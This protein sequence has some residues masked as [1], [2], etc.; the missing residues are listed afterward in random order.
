[1]KVWKT[2]KRNLSVSF[3]RWKANTNWLGVNSVTRDLFFPKC[4][5]AN[6]RTTE[7]EEGRRLTLKEG[8]PSA[9][10]KVRG[11]YFAFVL[12]TAFLVFCSFGSQ[13]RWVREREVRGQKW[14]WRWRW[15]ES[16]S[17][18]LL[19]WKIL[20]HPRRRRS[21]ATTG[22][23]CICEHRTPPNCESFCFFLWL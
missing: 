8:I 7:V 9:M 10:G 4:M 22:Y 15:Q 2:W 16:D 5:I 6:T 3:Q 13:W 12:F 17:K 18:Y 1:M 19:R 11:K 14:K 21:E 23:C 20:D